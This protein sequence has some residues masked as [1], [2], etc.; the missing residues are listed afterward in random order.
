MDE[1][2][3]GCAVYNQLDSSLAGLG[4]CAH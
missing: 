3:R 4:G 1:Q 2:S